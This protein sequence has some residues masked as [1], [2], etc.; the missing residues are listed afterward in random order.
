MRRPLVSRGVVPM[1]TQSFAGADSAISKALAKAKED[2]L[3][4]SGDCAVKHGTCAEGRHYHGETYL[5]N[6]YEVSR[7]ARSLPQA[8]QRLRDRLRARHCPARAPSLR[9]SST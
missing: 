3:V 4:V 6:I 7:P 1:R 5:E 8:G 2:G 9:R